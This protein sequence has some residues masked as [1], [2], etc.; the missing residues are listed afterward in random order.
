MTAIYTLW[1]RLPNDEGAWMIASEDEW[2]WSGD[3]D[4]CEAKFKEARKAAERDGN[5]VR[6]ITLYVDQELIEQAFNPADVNVTDVEHV[7]D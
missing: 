7:D 3:P 5:A 4:R 1:A 2:C 6:E